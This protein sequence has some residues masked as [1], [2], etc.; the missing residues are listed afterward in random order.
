M[1]ASGS[2]RL[3]SRNACSTRDDNGSC[4]GR[5]ASPSSW[6]A[7][8]SAGS[9]S[10]ASGFPPV[11]TTSRSTTPGAMRPPPV[12]PAATGTR[13]GQVRTG[14]VRRCRLDET[15]WSRCHGQRTRRSTRSAPRRREQNRS[16]SAVAGSS[17][18]ASS[19]THNTVCSSAAAVSSD[20]VATATR[21]GSTDGPSSSPNATRSARCCGA[22]RLVAEPHHRQQEPVECRERQRRLDLQTLGAQYG[23]F[24]GPG[25][26][27]VDERRLTDTW[28]ATHDDGI[29]SHRRFRLPGGWAEASRLRPR[30]ASPRTTTKAP[31]PRSARY[32]RSP[33]VGANLGLRSRLL[34][35]APR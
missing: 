23:H 19:T 30:P 8:S 35:Q 2:A 7:L 14:R 22:G 9:S 34:P 31:R 26:K 13:R 12:A 21:N 25:H 28:L 29:N 4:S 6:S 1:S 11:S 32:V 17:Q 10:S 15:T 3:R 24:R 27:V 20:S 5:G 16:T 33:I 18:C